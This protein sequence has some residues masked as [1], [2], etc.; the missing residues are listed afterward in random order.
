MAHPGFTV[1]APVKGALVPL[2]QVPD[3]VFSQKMLGDGLAIDPADGTLVA[4]FE[5]EIINIHPQRHALVLAKDGIEL[6]VHIGIDTVRLQGKGFTAL[7]HVGDKIKAG[8]PVL[9][10]DL[11]YISSHLK[12]P[13]VLCVVTTP[14]HA[15]VRPFACQFV[16]ATQPLFTVTLPAHTHQNTLATS[17]VESAP[18]CITSP[19]GLHARPAGILAR[20]C[21]NYAHPVF[22][23]KKEQCVNA[24]SVIGIMGLA[25]A[26]GDFITLRVGGPST[27]AHNF[28]ATITQSFMTNFDSK[29]PLPPAD[30]TKEP[31]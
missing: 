7:A 30:N 16:Q 6:L 22:I 31:A 4:P 9:N 14:S 21:G 23:C 10:F 5:G 25:L 15:K 3:P 24:K 18:I 28:I 20:L 26:Q 11:A 13:L 1:F 29:F 12:T 8:Q 27:Q 2:E 17:L 19:H